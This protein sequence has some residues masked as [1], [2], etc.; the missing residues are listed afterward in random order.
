M[1]LFS[2]FQN[3]SVLFPS[4]TVKDFNGRE[5][6]TPCQTPSETNMGNLEETSS[7]YQYFPEKRRH[8]HRNPSKFIIY[9][10]EERND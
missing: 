1:S 8:G 2:K 10:I 3:M 5:T 9:M 4:K 7:D 6:K